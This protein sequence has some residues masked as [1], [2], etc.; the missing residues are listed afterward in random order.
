MGKNLHGYRKSYEKGTLTRQKMDKDPLSQFQIWYAEAEISAADEENNIMTLSSI[1]RDGF[2]RGRIVLLKEV[3]NGGF[4]F[5]TNYQS[6]KGKDIEQN[7]RVCISFFWPVLERQAIIKGKAEKVSE[8]QSEVYFKTRPRGSQ[9]GALVSPQS[10]VV[11][12]RV[13]LEYKL[14]E[15]EGRYKDKEV[16]RPKHWGGYR[17]VPVEYEFWQGRADRLHDRIRYS[18]ENNN[19][20]IERLAP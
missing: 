1:G 19:W 18:L 20:K 8:E 3:D 12:N 5:Y 7:N 17:I 4:V 11:E 15:L 16:P 2:P 13:V 10:Q 14:K 6:D 9:F